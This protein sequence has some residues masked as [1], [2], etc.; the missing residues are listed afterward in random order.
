MILQSLAV[1]LLAADAG[2]APAPAPV[3]PP[4]AKPATVWSE[5]LQTPESVLYD[6]ASD[7]YLVSN[8]NG[9]P[10]EKDNNG[11]ISKL[12]PDGTVLTLKWI[13]GGKKGVTLNAPKGSAIAKGV[14]Y[15][16]DLDTVRK[17]DARTGAPKGEVKLP[18][19][20][21]A[22]DVAAGADGKIY[23]T[24]SGLKGGAKGFEPSGSDAIWVI[25]G[26]SKAKALVKADTLGR[27]NGIIVVGDALYVAQF[28]PEGLLLRV[29]AKGAVTTA[30]KLPH[31]AL[32]GIVSLGGEL[33]ISSWDGKSVYR[34][35]PQGPFLTVLDPRNFE[36]KDLEA[37]AD[38]G[39]DSK[40]GRLLVPRFMGN[41]VE[42][43]ELK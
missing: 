5:G 1:L 7:T 22:N 24:D 29:D 23:V 41:A 36:I 33:L 13:E 11:F 15:V 35:P 39:F 10:L 21:F 6:A 14:L 28:A 34:G 31:G 18:G 38:I 37:P 32:D 40:R 17:F 43:Y 20:T 4:A 9:S 25:E 2:T 8:I 30:G 26:G 42:A 27:P 19:A 16:A 12:K 3:T